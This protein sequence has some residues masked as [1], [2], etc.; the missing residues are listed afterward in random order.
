M[1]PSTGTPQAQE[2]SASIP[3]TPL[4]QKLRVNKHS[5][6]LFRRRR[7]PDWTDNYTLG[8]D[9][10][11]LNRLTQRQSVNIPLIKSTVKTLLKDIDEA[12]M[13]YFSELANQ[14]QA[15]VF[16]NEYW[17]VN[18]IQNKLILKDIMD[19]RQEMYFGRSFKFMNIVDG[20][21]YW[22]V[23]DPQDVLVDRYVDPSDIDTARFV[24]REHIYKPLSSLR[25]NPKLDTSAVRKLQKFMAT[26]EGLL[27]ATENQLDW[28][29]KQ[30]RMA[31]LGVI[32]TFAPILGETY[33]ELNEFWIKEWNETTKQ[34]EIM[35]VIT[36]EDMVVL[37]K[38]KL[39]ECIGKTIG[40]F[41][42]SHYPCTTWADET[43]TTDFWSDGVVDSIRTINKVLNAYISQNIENRT[44]RSFGMKF[45]N[46][47][48]GEEGFQPQTFE[49]VPFGMYPIPVGVN[50]KITDNI[51]D[52][53]IQPLD[54]L[55]N[56]IEFLMGLAQQSSAATATQQGVITPTPVTLG[57]V[58]LTLENAQ[59]R[60]KAMAVY[61]NASWQDFGL[62]F[63]KMLEAAPDLIDPITINK[64]GKNSGKNYSKVITP[65]DY[66]IG[67]QYDV[68]VRMREDV[69]RDTQNSLQKLQ[70]SKTLMP[71]NVTLD[72]IIKKKSLE[73]ADLKASDTDEIMKE[74][75]RL[76]TAMASMPAAPGTGGVVQPAPTAPAIA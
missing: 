25:T 46:S 72:N 36:A 32:D 70:Y 31:T 47:S 28:V 52:I 1:E 30:R 22:E 64:K 62:K 2:N 12:P 20:N 74:E 9:K 19:K 21:F 23:V 8:R 54:D 16:Y 43:E 41:W 18:S 35:Y 17:R 66:L 58:Q 48:L 71:M 13:L 33:V 14:D 7:Q 76:R 10:V 40:N 59:E 39:E 26:S 75:E 29:E 27:R 5:A 50:G 53:P 57:Q 55:K 65:K 63:T 34:D 51:M 68:E 61:Y 3:L 69:Q 37:Y 49:P 73:F 11:Q 24:I 56:D 44:L 4:M 38:A 15:E 42:Q 67:H 60:V 45:F 6:F